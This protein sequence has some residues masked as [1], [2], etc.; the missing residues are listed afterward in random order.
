MEKTIRLNR[1]V[2]PDCD[3]LKWKDTLAKFGISLKFRFSDGIELG[4]PADIL[5]P[6]LIR[7]DSVEFYDTKTKTLVLSYIE[8]F[9]R[10]E[11]YRANEADPIVSIKILEDV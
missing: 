5:E 7:S 8:N 2:W 10:I 3:D 6:G 1:E 9:G 11:F 4:Y